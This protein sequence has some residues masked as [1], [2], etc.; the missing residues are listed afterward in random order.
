MKKHVTQLIWTL[1]ALA[2]PA[3]GDD[4]IPVSGTTSPEPTASTAG[5][6]YFG[7]AP[8][9]PTDFSA[10]ATGIVWVD[11]TWTN[12]VTD[13]ATHE[14]AYHRSTGSTAPSEGDSDWFS[15]GTQTSPYSHV[16]PADSTPLTPGEQY[17]YRVRAS[18]DSEDSDWVYTSV[19]PVYAVGSVDASG[20]T[21]AVTLSWSANPQL[22]GAEYAISWLPP[23]ASTWTVLVASQTEASITHTRTFT[24]GDTHKYGVRVLH[25]GSKSE[26]TTTNV[27][28]QQVGTPAVPTDFSASATGLRS[29]RTDVD[30]QCHKP[31]RHMKSHTTGPLVQARLR[32]TTRG[33]SPL[34]HG[35]RGGLM[36]CLPTAR[37]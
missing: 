4:R 7:N 13:G 16:L 12:S 29:G 24:V 32:M 15:L 28:I 10:S 37:N 25:G 33:G 14:V 17:W 1:A 31:A 21:T 26:L 35:R 36:S 2:A 27:V 8:A 18:K 19:T 20:S 23:G 22:S 6:Y 30:E 11:L 34:E 3:S 5:T 9:V